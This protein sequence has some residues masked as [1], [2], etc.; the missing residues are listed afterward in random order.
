MLAAA[1]LIACED[2]RVTRRLLDHTASRRRSRPTTS[3]MPPR[4]GRSCSPACRPGPRSRWCPMPARRSISDP[5]F[6]LVRAA[7]E[8]GH[9]VTALPG[10]SAV[11][12]ALAVSRPADRPF[13]LRRIPAGEG[14]AAASRIAELARIP[15][16][17]VLFETGPRLAAA[18]ADLA[19]GLGAREAAVCR[20]LTKLHEEVRRGDLAELASDY[21][22]RRRNARRDRHRD[23]AARPRRKP[24]T[25]ADARRLCCAQALARVSVKEAV[26]EIAA[27]TGLPRR[28]VYQR[29]LALT[30]DDDH[31]DE[32]PRALAARAARRDRSGRWRS[33]SA[34][35]RKAAPRH[36]SSP[37]AFASWRGAGACPAGEIDI[38][39]R[40][41]NLLMFVE[42]KAREQLDDAA[43]SVTERQ[44]SGSPRRPKSGS[45]SIPTTR[46]RDIRFDAMLVAPRRCRGT[47]GGVR[48]TIC[49]RRLR[50][51]SALKPR[52]A[53]R[54]TWST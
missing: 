47:S 18:L 36:F 32:R 25:A 9:A 54:R 21:A 19:A 38:V 37:R 13:L 2:T 35:R 43:W 20:E 16:T 49:R 51:T 27:V 3:T 11:L 6:K 45:P 30:K 39:A 14:G 23:R 40:R 7:H 29:A 53:A 44:R 33:A 31:D 26:A 5:G 24:P 48:R 12:A 34:F 41:R 15:A 22:R 4:P 1:D 10:A 52:A 46:I 28:E 8:A 50:R 17:L 42:V